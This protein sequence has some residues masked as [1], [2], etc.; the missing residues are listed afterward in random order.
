MVNS[1]SSSSRDHSVF[2]MLGSSH[3]CQ[4]DLHCLAVFFARSEAQRAHWLSPYLEMAALR[5]SSSTFDHCPT[6]VTT[7]ATDFGSMR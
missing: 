7:I 2:L 4:R 6:L 5:T 3:S 1:F